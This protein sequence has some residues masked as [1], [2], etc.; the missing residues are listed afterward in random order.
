M[1]RVTLSVLLH[2]LRNESESRIC[3]HGGLLALRL[4]VS[5]TSTRMITAF[6]RLFLAVLLS[7]ELILQS[8]LS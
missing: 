1:Q 8:I 4:Q 3:L 5:E 7:G 6:G 2:L